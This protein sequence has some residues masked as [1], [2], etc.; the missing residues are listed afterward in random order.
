MPLGIQISVA[1]NQDEKITQLLFI[2][3]KDYLKSRA[4]GPED[5]AKSH[6]ESSSGFETY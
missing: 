6:G 1:L 5:G 3:S 4:K 2:K